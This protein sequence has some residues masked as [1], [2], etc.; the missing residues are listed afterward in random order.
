MQWFE[1]LDEGVIRPV[2]TTEMQGCKVESQLPAGSISQNEQK[3]GWL[4]K[5]ADGRMFDEAHH[6][7]RLVPKDLVIDIRMVLTNTTIAIPKIPLFTEFFYIKRNDG[8]HSGAGAVLQN[9][10]AIYLLSLNKREGVIFSIDYLETLYRLPHITSL[11]KMKPEDIK[12][13]ILSISLPSSTVIM[14]R[15]QINNYFF[16]YKDGAVHLNFP[17]P[18][19]FGQVIGMITNNI[20]N[21]LV[22]YYDQANDACLVSADNIF[23]MKVSL[24]SQGLPRGYL[25][26]P[27]TG[28]VI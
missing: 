8:Q 7:W 25:T 21:C 4:A 13:N 28:E 18:S 23:N 26:N 24:E 12:E 14:P 27:M 1:Q 5:T 9:G 22:L 20:G 16:Q 11:Q 19:L 3:S 10:L 2:T 17:V 15:R 6:E